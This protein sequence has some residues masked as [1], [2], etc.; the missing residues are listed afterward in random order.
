MIETWLPPVPVTWIFIALPGEAWI[1]CT[2][3]GDLGSGMSW[4]IPT[5]PAPPGM[6]GAPKKAVNIAAP[7]PTAPSQIVTF[8]F[9]PTVGPAWLTDREDRFHTTPGAAGAVAV[10]MPVVDTAFK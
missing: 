5:L 7:V 8:E 4:M 6:P 1:P 9:G 10:H 2:P 3:L